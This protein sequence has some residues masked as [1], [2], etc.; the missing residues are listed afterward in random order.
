M[1]EFFHDD[2]IKCGKYCIRPLSIAW[3]IVRGALSVALFVALWFAYV[4]FWT[5][6]QSPFLEKLRRI[7][8]NFSKKISCLFQ[9]TVI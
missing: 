4:G 8:S 7:T 3:F 1:F 5:L 2:Y 9:Y 6:F